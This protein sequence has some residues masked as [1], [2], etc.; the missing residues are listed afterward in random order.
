V[1]RNYGILLA[2]FSL[3]VPDGVVCFFPSYHYMVR[4][5]SLLGFNAIQ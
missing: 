1:I 3:A 5:I 4:N 2:E